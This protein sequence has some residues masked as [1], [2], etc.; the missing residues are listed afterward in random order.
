[1]DGSDSPFSI[2]SVPL[3]RLDE[4]WA[5]A[6]PLILPAAALSSGR[7][8]LE[9]YHREIAAGES[10]LWL[11][12]RG[13]VIYAA[14]ICAVVAYPRMKTLLVKICGGHGLNDWAADLDAALVDAARRLGFKKIE[15][16]GRKGWER[17]AENYGYRLAGITVEKDV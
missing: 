13:S 12:M 4:V 7:Y 16:F 1:M 6:E 10:E 5:L 17:F 8:S 11:V 15:W 9:D 3:D 14:A 2:V